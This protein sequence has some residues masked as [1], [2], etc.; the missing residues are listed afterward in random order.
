MSENNIS[1]SVILKFILQP[2]KRDEVTNKT[3]YEYT[4]FGFFFLKGCS[5]GQVRYGD[6]CYQEAQATEADIKT[7]VDACA[8]LDSFLWY[9]ETR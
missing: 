6:H 7:N 1:I 3:M 8:D 5:N 2:W 4:F 9:P